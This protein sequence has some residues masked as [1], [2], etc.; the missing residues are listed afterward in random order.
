MGFAPPILM[1][2]NGRE[3]EVGG[4]RNV[5]G[6]SGCDLSRNSGLLRPRFRGTE[7]WVEVFL[8]PYLWLW[9]WL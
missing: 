8:F 7:C 3:I 9:L 5:L 6:L 1:E 4:R 2:K